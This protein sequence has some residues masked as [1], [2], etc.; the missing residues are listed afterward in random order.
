VNT[1]IRRLLPQLVGL[2]Y[3]L[4]CAACLDDRVVQ[5]ADGR[6][7]PEG[8]ACDQAHQGCVLPQQL[9]G[10]V[11]KPQGSDCSYRGVPRGA[12]YEQVCLP[13]GC[14]NGILD[15]GEA[16]DDSNR[17]HGDGCSADCRSNEVCGNGVIDVTIG[18]SCERAS[19][20][21]AWCRDD[22]VSVRCGDGVR[23]GDAFELCDEGMANSDL[24]D[25]TC[26]PNCQPRRC[27]DGVHD[28]TEVCDDG[29]ALDG[30]GCSSDC[31]SDE[32]CGNG[33]VDTAAGESCDT[34]DPESAAWC[35][36]SCVSVR[37]GDGKVDQEGFER[38]DEGDQNSDEPDATCRRNCQP[39]RC[40]DGVR[41]A[42][43]VCDDGNSRSGDGCAA[44]CLS[45]E[46]CGNGVVDAAIGESCEP[47]ASNV[48]WC[49][50]NCVNVT[51]GDGV[52]DRDVFEQCDEGA[53]NSAAPDAACRPNCQHRRCGDGIQDSD[54]ACDDGNQVDRDGCSHD[55][56][57]REVCG[58][59]YADLRVGEECDDR[60]AMSHDGCSSR[61]R[62]EPPVWRQISGALVGIGGAIAY[63]AAR[64]AAVT[65]AFTR[66]YELRG[67]SWE[68]LSPPHLPRVT[69]DPGMTWDAA[70]R[71]VVLFGGSGQLE[72]DET[73]EWDGTDWVHRVP[74]SEVPPS[75]YG[76]VLT[77]DPVRGKTVMFG[78]FTNLAWMR[79]AWEWDGGA[80]RELTR[81]DGPPAGATAATYDPVRGRVVAFDGDALWYLEGDVWR[82]TPAP[83]PIATRPY[84]LSLAFDAE[85]G[86]LVYLDPGNR[87]RAV[88]TLFEWDGS[89]WQP[90]PAP[91][92]EWV[93]DAR[94][95][96]RSARRRLSLVSS[97]DV[98]ERQGDTWVHIGSRVE[99]VG[100][101]GTALAYDPLRGVTILFGGVSATGTWPNSVR[102]LHADTWQWDGAT[103]SERA[104]AHAPPARWMHAMAYDAGRKQIVLFGGDG[105]GDRAYLGDTWIWDGEDWSEA[106]PASA[107]SARPSHAMAYDAAREEVLLFG[108]GHYA[109]GF[110][111]DLWS[112]DGQT[113]TERAAAV[114]PLPRY[115]SGM[116]YDPVLREVVLAGG[117]G[118]IALYNDSPTWSWDGT[119]WQEAAIAGLS[120]RA[121]F[122]MPYDANHR[123]I[124]MIGGSYDDNVHTWSLRAGLEEP[125][126]PLPIP[127]SRDPDVLGPNAVY[128]SLRGRTLVF[129]NSDA[130]TWELSYHAE[131]EL[132][133]VC[134]HGRDVDGDG[135]IGCA[136]P[137]CWGYCTPFCP[138]GAE[139]DEAQPRCGDGTCNTALETCRMCPGDCACESL[140]GDFFCDAGETAATCPG[141]CARPS[142]IP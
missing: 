124:L 27:G 92:G 79:D 96:Y 118:D 17:F 62:S 91:M 138:P 43:E 61:C 4:F 28:S 70:R 77:Y 131:G 7:C 60:N 36:P 99:P 102:T 30:D 80:W 5:C 34:G 93:A 83:L 98:W 19:G 9:E 35:R 16:C 135:L 41:D 33:V 108:G 85:R 54:E 117:D 20:D 48:G 119:R 86:R 110:S 3:V 74:A 13:T 109:D 57:S 105:S 11:N 66:T 113:W 111:N 72:S 126:E 2:A 64:D 42:G 101:S 24:R 67:S 128:E 121:G 49:R 6:M 1:H 133:E 123:A 142:S 127:F 52:L 115:A 116:S 22:C 139:C 89:A 45:D 120:Y 55:C 63:D 136:D 107:P 122:A 129:A 103:W 32:S 114:A 39:Q 75:R 82:S 137:D 95:L 90:L 51:C 65:F 18:E 40:G 73:W 21:E 84:Q 130:P 132:Y 38:C 10:C 15:T 87:E 59:G 68:L 88:L 140:C 81:T 23:D 12:C 71:R 29:N 56:R 106:S 76:P 104:P 53:R 125:W 50:A 26:R 100:L 14:G 47:N 46:T 31:M 94:V 78:G 134:Q 112:W 8:L 97:S 58:N 37:C 44:D 141:D 69:Y 25:A